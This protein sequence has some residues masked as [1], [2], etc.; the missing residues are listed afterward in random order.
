MIILFFIVL[1][2]V[3]SLSPTTST[4]LSPQEK[5]HILA[6]QQSKKNWEDTISENN[7][8]LAA[9]AAAQQ[10]Y[11]LD[12]SA[13]REATLTTTLE[14]ILGVAGTEAISAELA[15][16]ERLEQ[17]SGY[18]LAQAQRWLRDEYA[19][20][21]LDNT[22][23]KSTIFRHGTNMTIY[24]I[25]DSILTK[26]ESLRASQSLSKK[27]PHEIAAGFSEDPSEQIPG[28]VSPQKLMRLARPLT[29][30]GYGAS[31]FAHEISTL[32]PVQKAFG[33]W[34]KTA[35]PVQSKT[36]KAL[37]TANL[38]ALAG[39][40]VHSL[41]NTE[42]DSLTPEEA[43]LLSYLNRREGVP[44]EITEHKKF[45]RTTAKARQIISVLGQAVLPFLT[46]LSKNKEAAGYIGNTAGIADSALSMLQR[47]RT[48][49]LIKTI[50]EVAPTIKHELEANPPTEQEKAAN[51]QMGHASDFMLDGL[52]L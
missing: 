1:F 27:T 22:P 47:Y 38:A 48:R 42:Y 18:Q 10:D 29:K 44:Q 5:R 6:A 2:G 52:L 43:A 34:P 32:A 28:M 7:A 14:Q 15:R 17:K 23:K 35:F 37:G 49:K 33:T 16:R 12:T 50:K 36:A 24:Q 40:T 4:P 3:V 11:E 45:M 8:V 46:A 30:L 20:P 51:R 39:D 21:P 19:Q 26:D 31:A 25:I 41:I 9:L 13:N